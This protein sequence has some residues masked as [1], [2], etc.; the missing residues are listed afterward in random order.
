MTR[1]GRSERDT[2]NEEDDKLLLYVDVNIGQGK[3]ARITIKQG[4]RIEV[5][6]QEFAKT[7]GNPHPFV[8]LAWY[9]A[10]SRD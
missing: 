5:V 7:Y 1:L 9:R 2:L 3:V 6:A 10:G 4:D 8:P